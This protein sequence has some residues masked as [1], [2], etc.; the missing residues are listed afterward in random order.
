M[1]QIDLSHKRALV[2][3]GNSGIGEAIALELALAGADVAINYVAQPHA[4]T[5]VARQIEAGG[6]RALTVEADV[7]D[8]AAVQNMIGQVEQAWGGLDVLINNAGIDGKRALGW[9]ADPAAWRKVLEVD[10]L[11]AFYCARAAMSGMISRKSGVVLNISSVHE[12]IPW[13]GYSAYTTSKAAL[14]MLTKTLAMEA[15]PFGVRVL[16]LAPGAIQTA[17]NQSV[18][19]DSQQLADLLTK[20]PIGRMGTTKEI[21]EM[22]ALLVSDAASYITGSTVFVD[23]GMTLYANFEQGG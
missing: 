4:A 11:G 6:R 8:P 17:I 16:A 5:A 2:T 22:A 19:S 10:L 1:I 12:I 18:W 20:I 9:E 23:G 14:G 3:G 13:S 21:A 15:A 7:S